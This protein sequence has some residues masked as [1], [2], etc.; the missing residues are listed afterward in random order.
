MAMEWLY[1]VVDGNKLMG[2]EAD[3]HSLANIEIG[4]FEAFVPVLNNT[5][6]VP[7]LYD[8]EDDHLAKNK[9][10]GLLRN[11]NLVSS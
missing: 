2:L 8:C 7:S 4:K 3:K 5:F 6:V 11:F 1:D 9:I 10:L